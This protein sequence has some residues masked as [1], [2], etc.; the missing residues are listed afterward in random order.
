M[1]EFF[2]C[3]AQLHLEC[4]FPAEVAAIIGVKRLDIVFRV[5]EGLILHLL[6]LLVPRRH[7]GSQGFNLFCLVDSNESASAQDFLPCL[8]KQV[9]ILRKCDTDLIE[10]RK[11]RML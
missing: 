1:V 5:G 7:H 8:Q 11:G 2:L 9:T 10:V 3:E 4:C 6:Q